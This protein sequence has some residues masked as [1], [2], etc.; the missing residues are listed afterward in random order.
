MELVFE[1]TLAMRLK[2]NDNY[3]KREMLQPKTPWNFTGALGDC[4]GCSRCTQCRY[5]AQ[6]REVMDKYAEKVLNRRV[7]GET[8]DR[9]EARHQNNQ[10]NT[11]HFYAKFGHLNAFVHHRPEFIDQLDAF[12]SGQRC[13]ELHADVGSHTQFLSFEFH[14]LSPDRFVQ[15][16]SIQLQLAPCDKFLLHKRQI[17]F[18]QRE[19]RYLP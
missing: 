10:A 13:V 4:P 9:V 6:A 15:D 17:L 8:K 2:G 11:K 18:C 12:L 19:D 1:E 3:M 14:Q 5:K 7:S 16:A